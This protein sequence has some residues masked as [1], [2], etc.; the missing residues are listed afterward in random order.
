LIAFNIFCSPTLP[1]TCL[2]PCQNE[3]VK[4]KFEITPIWKRFQ[5]IPSD[6]THFPAGCDS[7]RM[8]PTV[9]YGSAWNRLESPIAILYV[10][11]ASKRLEFPSF[12]P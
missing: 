4:K 2:H 12:F 3:P 11:S 9:N 7:K 5:A 6:S 1:H 8:D 10:P